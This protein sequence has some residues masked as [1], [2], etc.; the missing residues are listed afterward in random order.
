MEELNLTLPL[1][2]YLRRLWCSG[3]RSIHVR[4]WNRQKRSW[5]EPI[6][7]MR[8]RYAAVL[9]DASTPQSSEPPPNEKFVRWQCDWRSSR[10][11]R[12]GHQLWRS[13]LSRKA[14]PRQIAKNGGTKCST[15]VFD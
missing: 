11:P 14:A 12:H 6:M 1:L 3:H 9:E 5:I 15:N 7:P 13:R 4:Q 2:L 10:I 8:R